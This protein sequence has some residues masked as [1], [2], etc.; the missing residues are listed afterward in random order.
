MD[1]AFNV[2]AYIAKLIV[3]IELF[4]VLAVPLLAVGAGGLFGLRIARRRLGGPIG[5][6]RQVPQRG[7]ALVDRACTMAAMPV[8]TA[9]SLWRA[10][11]TVMSSL[12]RQ[13]SGTAGRS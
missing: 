8:I 6:A 12:R 9:S 4:V 13:R 5:I 10:A 1:T 7:Q 2:I 3:L 11:A